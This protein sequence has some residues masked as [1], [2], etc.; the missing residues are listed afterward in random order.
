MA[1]E[2]GETIHPVE[3]GYKA[4]RQTCLSLLEKPDKKFWIIGGKTGSGKTE[5]IK[6]LSNSI[7]L[8]G[9]HH[10]EDQLSVG[11]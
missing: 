7:D 6:S 3:G 10:I 9:E 11:S 5:I 2:I 1:Q 4:L 8:E